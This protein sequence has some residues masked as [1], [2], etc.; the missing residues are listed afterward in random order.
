[1]VG[2]HRKFLFQEL[3]EKLG[4][5]TAEFDTALSAKLKC[6]AE[7]DATALTIN[8]ANRLVGGLASENVRWR[9]SVAKLVKNFRDNGIPKTSFYLNSIFYSV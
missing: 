5:L 1:M 2:T 9:Q 4:K 8:L 6:Q 3:E 7:A